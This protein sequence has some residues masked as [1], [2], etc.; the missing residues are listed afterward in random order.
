M[1]KERK[2]IGE[3]DMYVPLVLRSHE[4]WREI[5]ERSFVFIAAIAIALVPFVVLVVPHHGPL[6]PRIV[7]H[8]AAAPGARRAVAWLSVGQLPDGGWPS[9]LRE[10]A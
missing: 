5:E 3:G 10:E 4:L 7:N 2:A 8:D 9:A 6:L 1:K